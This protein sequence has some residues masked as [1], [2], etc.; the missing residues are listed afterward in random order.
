VGRHFLLAATLMVLSLRMIETSIAQEKGGEAGNPVVQDGNTF[1][2][3]PTGYFRKLPPKGSVGVKDMCLPEIQFGVFEKSKD[4]CKYDMI[5][6]GPN[7]A[8][9][10]PRIFDHSLAIAPD[11]DKCPA[12]HFRKLPPKGSVGVKDMCLPEIQFGVFEKP[13]DGCKYGMIETGPNNAFCRPRIF[14]NSLAIAPKKGIE[15]C[16]YNEGVSIECTEGTYK[17]IGNNSI[18]AINA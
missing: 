10:R 4:G 12:G 16:N 15:D 17:F 14:D 9:C 11:G 2:G 3:C 6:T 8:F 1:K 13:K 5:E 7:N 18:D